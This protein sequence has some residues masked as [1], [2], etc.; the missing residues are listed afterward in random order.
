[1]EIELEQFDLAHL[2]LL[3]SIKLSEQCKYERGSH[4][5]SIYYQRVLYSL[6]DQLVSLN[7]IKENTNC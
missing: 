4:A 5:F 1:M 3:E 2:H 7:L 6:E